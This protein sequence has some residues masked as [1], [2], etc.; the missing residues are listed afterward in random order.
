MLLGLIKGKNQS[1]RESHMNGLK[2][3]MKVL[4]LAG[5]GTAS[6]SDKCKQNKK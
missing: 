6:H 2:A 3:A 1:S 4:V 5:T